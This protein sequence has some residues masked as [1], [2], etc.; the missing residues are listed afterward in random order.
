MKLS[1]IMPVYNE[2]STISKILRLVLAADTKDVKKEIIIVD[3]FSTDSTREVLKHIKEPGIKV[4]Y[5][6]KNL[7]KG[8]A[9]RTALKKATGDIIIIQ[10][11]DL[12]YE[13]NEYYKLIKPI[14]DGRARVVYGSR[15]LNKENRQHSG[16][17]YT[18][19]GL[20]LT[21]FT[22]LLYNTRITDES[23]CY[24]VFRADVI[25][26]IP[27]ECKR[28]EF[29]PEITAK[30]ALRKIRIMEVPISYYPRA[31]WQGKKIR[32]RDGAQAAMTLIKYWL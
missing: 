2:A 24:K 21:W 16:I 15:N 20:F 32:W 28:F 17:S 6:R 30:V 7:G 10:D 18:I 1:I 3:D 27:L 4:L 11:A 26:G 13:P 12:E 22:N 14:L 5:H 19:G 8:M 29:C 9:I 23:T 25:K 31:K